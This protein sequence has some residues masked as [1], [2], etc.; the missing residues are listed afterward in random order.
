MHRKRCAL[1]IIAEENGTIEELITILR[2]DISLDISDDMELS[3]SVAEEL[4]TILAVIE[5]E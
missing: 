5:N 1:A 2:E 4:E 3:D